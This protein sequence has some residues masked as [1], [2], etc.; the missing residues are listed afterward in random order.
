[1]RKTGAAENGGGAG[2]TGT[3]FEIGHDETLQRISFK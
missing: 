2:W 3:S 1:M